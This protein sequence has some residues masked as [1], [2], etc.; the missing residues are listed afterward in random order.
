MLEK[1][2]KEIERGG[3]QDVTT[4]A[5]RLNTSPEMIRMMLEQLARMG[6][7]SSSSYCAND[8]CGG[9][10]LADFCGPKADKINLWEYRGEVKS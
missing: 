7:L 3:T 8:G 4:L 10:S 1:L 2:L 6:R 9:C 5:Y